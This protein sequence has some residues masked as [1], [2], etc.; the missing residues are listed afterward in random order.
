MNTVE[1][2]ESAPATSFCSFTSAGSWVHIR[3]SPT[4]HSSDQ[5]LIGKKR[6]RRG[7][8]GRTDAFTSRVI[9]DRWSSYWSMPLRTAASWASRESRGGGARPIVAVVEGVRVGR[10]VRGVGS[11]FWR[12]SVRGE[13]VWLGSMHLHRSNLASDAFQQAASIGGSRLRSEP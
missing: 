10:R 5:D 11:I 7:E 1:H 2:F 13:R 8:R 3:R 9:M 12:R 6:E 4:E